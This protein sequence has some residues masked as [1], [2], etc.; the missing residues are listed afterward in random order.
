MV[1]VCLLKFVVYLLKYAL[2]NLYDKK[3]EY[4]NYKKEYKISS[5]IIDI[6]LNPVK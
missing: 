3:P 4:L 5:N 2:V 1:Y 6:K